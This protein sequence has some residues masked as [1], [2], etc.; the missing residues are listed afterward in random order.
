MMKRTTIKKF[1]LERLLSVFDYLLSTFSSE[2]KEN[3]EMN[4]TVDIYAKI[5]TLV[6]DGL[7]RK[8]INRAEDPSSIMFKI[9]FDFDFVKRVADKVERCC[10]EEFVNPEAE[11]DA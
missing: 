6:Q 8:N 9:D 5:N 10:L 7:L 4:H 3:Y 11:L 2:S 1:S